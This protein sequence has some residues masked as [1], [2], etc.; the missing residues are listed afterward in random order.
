MDSNLKGVLLQASVKYIANKPLY[1]EYCAFIDTAPLLEAYIS[2]YDTNAIMKSISK[3]P[4]DKTGWSGKIRNMMARRGRP[5]DEVS[6]NT[7]MRK[8]NDEAQPN[9]LDDVVDILRDSGFSDR[10]INKT[11]R[12]LGID[13][14]KGSSPAIDRLGRAILR[15]EIEEPIIKFLEKSVTLN[16]SILFENTK[17]SDRQIK[18]MFKAILDIK[19]DTREKD[20]NYE[21]IKTW[22]K[23][24]NRAIPSEKLRLSSEMLDHLK[25]RYGTEEHKI[26][27]DAF[28]AILQRSDL[29]EYMIKSMMND[30]SS[31]KSYTKVRIDTKDPS[32][33]REWWDGTRYK[34]KEKQE[35]PNTPYNY[36]NNWASEFNKG[37]MQ[38]KIRLAKE[39]TNHLA[40]R[41]GTSE[42]NA[43]YDIVKKVIRNSYLPNNIVK[44]IFKRIDNGEMFPIKESRVDAIILEGIFTS[45]LESNEVTTY[46]RARRR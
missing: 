43:T 26:L 18:F 32:R 45:I 13:A 28:K 10:V 22:G 19:K 27:S 46:G 33:D 16:E 20:N 31:G 4:D 21:Y 35:V 34:R 2:P 23:T 30:V 24:F 29:P 42:H 15:A 12:K 17:L 37:G 8:W 1:D 11:M 7:L 6:Y 14:Q 40:D 36:L 3:S 5:S 39:I 41:Y 9:D 38:A 25:D 44:S